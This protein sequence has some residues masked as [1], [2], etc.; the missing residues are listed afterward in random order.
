MMILI[1]NSGLLK[2][3]KMNLKITRAACV[4]KTHIDSYKNWNL[5]EKC[6]GLF[7]GVTFLSLDSF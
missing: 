7:Y 4:S 2:A 3:T 6:L 5:V 1:A